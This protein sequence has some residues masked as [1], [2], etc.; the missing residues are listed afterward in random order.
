MNTATKLLLP[1]S[2]VAVLAACAQQ[3]AGDATAAAPATTEVTPGRCRRN[4][5]CRGQRHLRH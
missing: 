4:R 3:P 2:L 5:H 1:L